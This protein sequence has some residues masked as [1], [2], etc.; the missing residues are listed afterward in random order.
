MKAVMIHDDTTSTIKFKVDNIN[1]IYSIPQK[2]KHITEI[3]DY[4]TGFLTMQ[5]NY[6]EEYTDLIEIV[7]NSL[8]SDKFKDDA[9]QILSKLKLS[10][11]T[12]ERG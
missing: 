10:D 9:E 5:T 6:G 11:I 2:L 12:L 1:L 4:D 8:F 7:K 3:S